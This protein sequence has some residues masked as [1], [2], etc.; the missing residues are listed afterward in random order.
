MTLLA[1]FG[2][3]IGAVLRYLLGKIISNTC[4]TSFPLGTWLIN[5]SGSYC[6]GL[7]SFLFMEQMVSKSVWLFVGV[8]ILG[9]YTTFSTFGYETMQL[10]EGKRWNT[11]IFYVLTSVILGLFAAWIGGISGRIF[12]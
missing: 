8:G 9:A 10:I 11:A 3:I 6:L 5:L 1:G 4:T 12:I 7:T 2:G